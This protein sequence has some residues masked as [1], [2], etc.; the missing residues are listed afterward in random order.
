MRSHLRR[1][2]K[3]DR[4]ARAPNRFDRILAQA[5]RPRWPWETF[6]GSEAALKWSF[7]DLRNLD[8]CLLHVPGR[9]A[10]VQAGGNIGFFPKRLAEEFATVYTFEPDPVLFRITS[11]TACERNVIKLQAAVGYER[12]GIKVSQKRRDTSGRAEHEG[13]THVAGA[14]TIPTLRIDDLGLEACD[15]IYLDIEGFEMPALV[16]AEATI[17]RCRPVLALE[18]NGNC[19]HYGYTEDQIRRWITNHHYERK[20]AM[21]S[22]EVWVPT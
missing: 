4:S 9:T 5:Y 2:G 20:I 8:E 6:E 12:Q 15:L 17:N 1:T 3:T 14:G 18:L 7:R 22:D 21:N 11:K 16:G 10:A 19:Q 13:L